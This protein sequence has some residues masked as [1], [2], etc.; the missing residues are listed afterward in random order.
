M[1]LQCA[2]SVL[3]GYLQ[4]AEILITR[5]RAKKYHLGRDGILDR[6]FL[7]WVI[8]AC[9]FC[10]GARFSLAVAANFN[11]NPDDERDYYE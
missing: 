3:A 9:L 5:K 10:A 8:S 11:N 6:R 7:R 2:C 1:C 4:S